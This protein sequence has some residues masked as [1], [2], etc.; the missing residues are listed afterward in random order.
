MT[1]NILT[2]QRCIEYDESNDPG[3]Y[4][5]RISDRP[6]HHDFEYPK[7]VVILPRTFTSGGGVK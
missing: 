3:S 6:L 4:V 2:S 5:N 7:S 1:K